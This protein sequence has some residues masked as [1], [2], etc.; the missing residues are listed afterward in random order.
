MQCKG[1]RPHLGARGKS[2]G[3]FHVAAGTWGTFSSYGGDGHSKLE[4]GQQ[5]LDPCLVTTE[6][7]GI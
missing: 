2:H 3:F 1:I 4:F 5:R 7:L 6:N